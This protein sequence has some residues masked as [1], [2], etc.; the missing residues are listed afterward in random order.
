MQQY[1]IDF[2]SWWKSPA[3]QKLIVLDNEKSEFSYV[4]T[5][6][7]DYLELAFI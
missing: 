6:C 7:Y 2:Y 1:P 4:F 3:E 5:T